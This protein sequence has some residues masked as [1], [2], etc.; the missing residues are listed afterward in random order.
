MDIFKKNESFMRKLHSLSGVLPLGIFLPF[1]L[2]LNFSS[3]WGEE[4]YDVAAGLLGKIPFI[5]IVELIIIFIP[6]LFHGIYGIY[7]ARQ[8]KNNIHQYKYSRNWFFF[9]QRI[10]GFIAF[11]FIT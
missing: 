8:T 5:W 11:A 4:T 9:L 1:H 6:I 10:T 7:I 3:V 2:F